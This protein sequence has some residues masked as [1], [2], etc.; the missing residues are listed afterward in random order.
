EIYVMNPDG[1]S[2]K[3]ITD[4][5]GMD[6][7]PDWS[8]D[9]FKMVFVSDRNGNQ[10]IYMAELSEEYDII[11]CIQVTNDP[12]SDRHPV[13]QPRKNPTS[14]K[15]SGQSFNALPNNFQLFQNY[16]N[17]FNSTT[18]IRYHLPQSGKMSLQIFDIMGRLVHTL[19]DD[20]QQAGDYQISWDG[21]DKNG[22]QVSTGVYLCQL[23]VDRC[24]LT[25][26]L[27]LI[28]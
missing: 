20:Q 18:T 13:W 27:A 26:K 23:T 28:K 9:G 4:H 1:S 6:I 24:K 7:E 22:L 10:D 16:P 11:R 5:P 19:I 21:T 3:K 8:Y 12:S 17:P 14:V 15:E 2:Q 25:N